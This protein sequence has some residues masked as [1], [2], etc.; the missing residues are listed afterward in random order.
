MW[1]AAEAVQGLAEKPVFIFA[2][3]RVT[4]WRANNGEFIFWQKS[5]A[6]SIFTI[7]LLQPS[8]SFYGFGA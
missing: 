3:S 2:E 6:K 8:L 1:A 5:M 7:P 4:H